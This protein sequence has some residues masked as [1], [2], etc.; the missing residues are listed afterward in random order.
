MSKTYTNDGTEWIRK[1]DRIELLDVY[2][3]YD[4]CGEESPILLDCGNLAEMLRELGYI[5]SDPKPLENT[6]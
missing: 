3:G 6:K 1:G 4:G 2:C 5:V